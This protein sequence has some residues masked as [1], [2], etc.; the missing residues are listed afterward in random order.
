MNDEVT[1]LKKRIRDLEGMKHGLVITNAILRERPD[2]PIE[3]LPVAREIAKMVEEMAM[4]RDENEK[5][6]SA[7]EE[8]AQDFEMSLQIDKQKDA[9]TERLRAALRDIECEWETPIEE[10]AWRDV[11]RFMWEIARAALNDNKKD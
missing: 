9:E 4:L 6:K 8:H 5:L 3:R 11:A 2:L 7:L 1:E 10:K